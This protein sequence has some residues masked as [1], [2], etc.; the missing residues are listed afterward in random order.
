MRKEKAVYQNEKTKMYRFDTFLFYSL[1][2]FM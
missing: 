1:I 2:I